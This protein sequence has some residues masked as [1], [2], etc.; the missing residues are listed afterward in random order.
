L[1]SPSRRQ[2]HN[3]VRKGRG[4]K[5]R[6]VQNKIGNGEKTSKRLVEGRKFH[7]FSGCEA[8]TRD[9]ER[10]VSASKGNAEFPGKKRSI[11]RTKQNGVL[12]KNMWGKEQ[13]KGFWRGKVQ[14][15]PYTRRAVFTTSAQ[16]PRPW[17]IRATQN[18]EEILG[19]RIQWEISN[20]WQVEGKKTQIRI[21]LRG[22]KGLFPKK[23]E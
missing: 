2:M 8:R 10:R 4:V 14:A 22:K 20:N 23:K 9:G 1:K 16:G 21:S 11:C 19:W 13:R 12:P 17:N 5:R 7:A 18:E 15:I 6:R 3:S